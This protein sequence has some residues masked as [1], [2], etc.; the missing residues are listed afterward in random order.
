MK[1]RILGL[2]GLLL[3]SSSL[4]AMNQERTKEVAFPAVVENVQQQL[5]SAAKAGETERIKTLLAQGALLAEQDRLGYTA[6]EWAAIHGHIDC[7]NIF[8]DE[9]ENNTPPTAP[10]GCAKR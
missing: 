10:R 1:E 5:F 4:C 3:V 7:V 6:F 9:L 2:I 8:L